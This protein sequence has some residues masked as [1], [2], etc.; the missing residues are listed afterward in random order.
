M[1]TEIGHHKPSA[2]SSILCILAI[3]HLYFPSR[4]LS[5]GHRRR[6]AH[7]LSA[8]SPAHGS[9]FKLLNNLRGVPHQH[10]RSDSRVTSTSAP[11]FVVHTRPFP[12]R[13]R[14]AFLNREPFHDSSAEPTRQPQLSKAALRGGCVYFAYES[15]FRI[16]RSPISR[17]NSTR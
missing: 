6:S 2:R 7:N 4:L 15:T 8:F 12:P 16:S 14:I 11:A 5:R 1:R 13:N 9:D 3:I 10:Y 17:L